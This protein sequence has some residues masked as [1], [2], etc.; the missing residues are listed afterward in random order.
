ME[1]VS[2]DLKRDL[3]RAF[4]SQDL[5]FFELC[6]TGELAKRI[7]EDVQEFKESF[8]R[9]YFKNFCVRKGSLK[10]LRTFKICLNS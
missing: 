10:I 1:K 9:T 2:S 4:Q 5:T 6:H 7:N 8:Y 3:F